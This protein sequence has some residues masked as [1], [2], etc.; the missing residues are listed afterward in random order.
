VTKPTFA[1]NEARDQFVME[2]RAQ[3]DTLAAIGAVLGVGRERVRQII[4]RADRRNRETV[5]VGKLR[6]NMPI[7]A[8]GLGEHAHNCIVRTF[9][10]AEVLAGD[11][12][13]LTVGQLVE[14]TPA[15]LRAISNFGAVS[16]AEVQQAL[17]RHGLSLKEDA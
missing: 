14:H 16:L 17:A 1:S 13:T 11:R 7:R 6:K 12:R 8:L 4:I 3:G 10:R 15:E 9:L 5:P 2:R